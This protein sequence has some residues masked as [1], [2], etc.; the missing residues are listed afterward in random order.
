MGERAD[1]ADSIADSRANCDHLVADAKRRLEKELAR[2]K[3]TAE[4]ASVEKEKTTKMLLE[5]LA[6]ANAEVEE[7]RRQGE[8]DAHIIRELETQVQTMHRLF[9]ELCHGQSF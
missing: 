9:N 4:A 5:H 1:M 6:R 8:Q 3:A 2:V 7:T